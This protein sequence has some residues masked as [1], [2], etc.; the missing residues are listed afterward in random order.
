MWTRQLFKFGRFVNLVGFFS[1]SFLL[2]SFLFLNSSDASA[3]AKE[4]TIS[5][6]VSSDPLEITLPGDSFGKTSNLNIGVHTDNYSGFKLS[7]ASADSPYLV[8]GEAVIPSIDTT[9]SEETYRSDNNYYNTFGYLPSQYISPLGTVITNTNYL[10]LPSVNGSLIDVTNAANSTDKSYTISFAAKSNGELPTGDYEYTFVLNAV[11]NM[12][13]YNV[14]Y[15]PNTADTV[16]NMPTPNPQI[17]SIQGGTPVAE[18]YAPLSSNVPLREDRSFGGW[19]DIQPTYNSSTGDDECS[20]TTYAAGSDYPIDQTVDGSNITLYAIWLKDPFPI[21]WSQM[22]ACE[23]HGKTQGNITGSECSAYSNKKF[24]DTGIGL[25]SNENFSKDYEIHFKIVSYDPH[26]QDDT[27]DSQQTFVSDKLSTSVEQSPYDKKAPGVIVR[28]ASDTSIQVR[29]TYGHGSDG[30]NSKDIVKTA[31]SVTEISVMRIDGEIY[32]SFNNGPLEFIQKINNFDQQF[33]L[34]T[35]FGAYPSDDCTGNET[36]GVCTNAKR[37]IEATLSEMYIRLGDAKATR[38]HTL[39]FYSNGGTPPSSTMEVLDG[40]PIGRFPQIA[41][42]GWVFRGWYTEEEGGTQINESWIPHG[43]EEYWAHWVKSVLQAFFETTDLQIAVKGSQSIVVT[44]PPGELEN[45]TFSSEDTSIAKVD[46][47][48]GVVTGVGVGSTTI[49]MHGTE[50]GYEMYLN[51]TVSDQLVPV[52]F[53]TGQGSSV[54]PMNIG[55]GAT[56]STLPISIMNHYTLDGWYTGPNGTGTKLTTSLQ[57]NEPMTFI[58]NWIETTYVCKKATELHTETCDR[59]TQGCRTNN[60]YSQ[61]DTITYGTIPNSTT[62]SPG[63]AYTCDI[64]ANNEFDE[65]FERFYYLGTSNGRTALIWHQNMFDVSMS[66]PSGLTLLPDA[67]EWRSTDIYPQEE[68]KIARYM[69]LSEMQTACG[70]TGG[71]RTKACDYLMEKTN[72]ANTGLQ[73]GI[74]MQKLND[75]A[76]GGRRIHTA[77]LNVNSVDTSINGSKNAPRPVIE[78]PAGLIEPYSETPVYTIIFNPHN[79][80]PSN[81]VHIDDGEPL[82]NDF[83]SHDPQYENHVF[84]G[85][86]TAPQGGDPVTDQ[87]IP[88][89]DSTY[90]AQWKKSVSLAEIANDDLVVIEN[91]TVS[92]DV[93]NSSELEPYTFRSNDSSKATVDSTTGVI[94]GVSRGET[95]ITL[96]GTESGDTKTIYINVVSSTD[97]FTISFDSEGGSPVNDIT[98]PAGRSIGADYPVDPLY[99]NHVFEGWFTEAT[100]GKLITS[101]TIPSHS[102]TY[103]AH[104]KLDVTQAII[105]NYDLTLSVGGQ[106]SVG[107][108][109]SDELEPYTF[110]SNDPS[111]ATVDATSGVITG[112]GAGTTNIVMTG[113]ESHLTKTL[114]V[115]VTP[116]PVTSYLVTFETNS[117]ESVEPIRVNAG[118]PVGTLPTITRTNYK[119]FGW[120][121]D[122]T[123]FEEVYPETIINSDVTYYAKWVEDTASFPVVWAETDACIFGSGNVS[124]TYCDADNKTK[125]YIDTGKQLFSEDNIDDEFEVGFTIVDYDPAV[126]VKQA[127]IVNSKQENSANNYPGF[128]FRRNSDNGNWLE[129]TQK[130]KGSGNNGATQT[131]NYSDVKSVKVYRRKETVGGSV[132]T[133]IYYSINDGTPVEFQDITNI[134]RFIFDTNVWFGVATTSSGGTQRPL[135]G[136][137]TDMYIRIGNKTDYTINFDANGGSVNPSSVSIPIGDPIGTLP[138]PTPASSSFTFEAWYDESVTPAVIVTPATTPTHDSTYVA[139]WHY[140]S[141]DV[142]VTFDVSNDAT[143][144]YQDIID[145]WIGSPVNLTTFNK[146]SPINSSTWGDTLVLSEPNYW[147]TLK[148]SFESND[149]MVPSYGDA[150]TTSVNPTAWANGTVDCSKPDAYDTKIR[151][152]LNVYLYDLDNSSTGQQVFYTKS[153]KGVIYNMIPGQTYY[154]EKDGDS[155]VH[156]YVTATSPNNRRW[157]DTGQIRNTRDLG[158][159]PVSYEKNGNTVTG[160]VAYGKLFRGERLWSAPGNA[161]ELTNLGITKEYDLSDGNE[162]SGDTRLSDYQQ[163]TVVHYNIEV[164]LSANSNYMKAWNAVTD[165]MTDVIAGKNIYFHCRVG[166]DRTGTIAYI[167]EGLLGVQNEDRHQEYSLTHLSGLYD[168]TRYYKM[169]DSGN[170]LKFVFM[171]GYLQN[172]SDIYDWYMANP[173]ADADLISDFRRHMVIE[174]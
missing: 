161:A 142:P 71:L 171:M 24:I 69:K 172:T 97:T 131:F 16:T 84:Q 11:G 32:A 41:R 9:L 76:T 38:L 165:I 88:V 94:T 136:T 134:T 51:V 113:S 35:W 46:P 157:V 117:G 6:S 164:D 85:W 151:A 174:D 162:L 144:D 101:D 130:W 120:Y 53:E 91:N 114:E 8:N 73:D 138:T 129:L 169:K 58:A 3:I 26:D 153:S 7:V 44:N 56:I 62:L 33:A 156:G 110:I 75:S 132:R 2:T 77:A 105:S 79:N 59:T 78:L 5:M 31:A 90:H 123:L 103:Y 128:V 72:F 47:T 45:Y 160:T 126:N 67:N 54:S 148:D 98:I 63:F 87:T 70:N 118:D 55:R 81:V 108:T 92:I 139:H 93:T 30:D 152:P 145:N 102:K 82:G 50:S 22:G 60:L 155:S 112:I 104:W 125:A 115:E 119:F 173:N 37:Y 48:T 143:R 1:F 149:C 106:I 170:A 111:V 158:G 100:G 166:A 65:D 23:F 116:A 122:P 163:D 49:I 146:A 74:W 36:Q 140:Q 95:T 43:D 150:K 64:N 28:R 107:V 10:P 19:C 99:A 168:R 133:K 20:G 124:G 80:T 40:S 25:Y 14:L 57:I 96:T 154:W 39:K 86:Y 18:S 13:E 137:L 4:S 68:G 12:I 34:N 127:T 61:G 15:D 29:H 89:S 121:E 147:T 17:L 21:V 83:P 167:L 66:Y 27:E 52:S 141:S 135:V 109:N 159:L 42:Q